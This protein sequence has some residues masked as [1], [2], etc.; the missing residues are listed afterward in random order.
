M[1]G[2]PATTGTKL[3]EDLC[4]VLAHHANGVAWCFGPDIHSILVLDQI[5]HYYCFAVGTILV[6]MLAS[7]NVTVHRVL[8]NTS[9]SLIVTVLR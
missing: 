9:V 8:S 1:T 3:Q 7:D 2:R 4:W 5:P 6:Y